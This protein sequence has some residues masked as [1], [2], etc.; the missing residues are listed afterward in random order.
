[1]RWSQVTLNDVTPSALRYLIEFAYTSKLFVTC[2]HALDIFEAAD[3]FQFPSAK[4][5]CEDFLA[6]QITAANCLNFMLYADAYSC[7][8]IYEK[9]GKDS[10]HK[11]KSMKENDCTFG[12]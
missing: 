9:V 2:D 4:L 3:M 7:E 10:V 8:R 1:M 11:Q 12:D 6:D 5:F